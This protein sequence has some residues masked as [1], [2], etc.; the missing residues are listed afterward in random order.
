MNLPKFEP[1]IRPMHEADMYFI[2]RE[3]RRGGAGVKMFQES[4]RGL[5]QR[6]VIRAHASFKV[7]EDHRKLFEAMGW[8]LTDC[9]VS[10][11]LKGAE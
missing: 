6:G 9:T 5:R 7:H 3:Y 8:E 2:L 10:K 11:V 4:E 1:Q